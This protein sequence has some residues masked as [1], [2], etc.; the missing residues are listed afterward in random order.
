LLN[1]ENMETVVITG[2]TGMIGSSLAKLL[3][4]NGYEVALLSRSA[5]KSK[6]H[7]GLDRGARQG[8]ATFHWD[9][10]A[11]SI[12]EEIIRR[13]DYIINLAGAG[14]A[15]KRWTSSR[16]REI[17]ESRV[18]SG[19]L[20]VKSL[21]EI[22]NSVKAVISISG[23]GWYGEDSQIANPLPFTEEMPA[24][25]GF[26]GQTCVKWEASVT[27]VNKLGK[28]LVIFRT[29]IVL[30]NSGG[31]LVEFKR[32]LRFGIATIL[33]TGK[34]VVS[35]IHIDDICRLFLTAIRD[36]SLNGVYNAV[37]PQPVTNRQLV[38]EL[39]KC[40]QRFY[41]PITVPAFAL[42]VA[43]GEV[44]IEVLKSATVSCDKLLEKGFRFSFPTIRSALEHLIHKT[45]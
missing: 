26:L 44:S 40:R 29:G 9:P 22:P 39:A 4:D 15:D 23:I 45:D 25:Q 17:V 3:A 30:S 24:D 20:I 32:P 43:L 28:R 16:K 21:N 19:E 12:D 8:P 37:S 11:K 5:A 36:P 13:A 42:K 6:A 7:N 31:A 14:V 41:I 10:A 18:Q 34:Q 1:L 35:W 33:G 27:P 2:G 38:L